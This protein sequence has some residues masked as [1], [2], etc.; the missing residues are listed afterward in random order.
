MPP[1]C[2]HFIVSLFS[3]LHIFPI[4][5]TQDVAIDN[6]ILNLLREFTLETPDSEETPDQNITTKASAALACK[7]PFTN[8][9][10]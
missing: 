10:L 1:D 3:A 6:I 7:K 9:E 5:N 8:K 4:L 2:S